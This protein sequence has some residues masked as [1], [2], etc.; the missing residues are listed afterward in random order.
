VSAGTFS[1]IAIGFINATPV[2]PTSATATR[3]APSSAGLP[4]HRGHRRQLAGLPTMA[5][6]PEGLLER[7]GL[8]AQA[9]VGVAQFGREL[10]AEVL[11]LEDRTQLDLDAP[12]ERRA[13]QP[14]DRRLA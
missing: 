10:L 14:V 6:I 2:G 13:L 5:S 7:G 8:F 11:G 1:T 4:G 3:L 9:I 12:V